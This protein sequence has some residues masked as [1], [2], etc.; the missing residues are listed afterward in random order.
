MTDNKQNQPSSNPHG[1]RDVLKSLAI[2]AAA[3]GSVVV[4]GTSKA[5]A[6]DNSKNPA[7]PPQGSSTQDLDYL[8]GS[9]VAEGRYANGEQ[10]LPSVKERVLALKSLGSLSRCEPFASRL[11]LSH[12]YP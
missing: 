10:P 3:A 1:R 6:P 7:P 12:A 2:A 4:P 8:G 11:K 9:P 5:K